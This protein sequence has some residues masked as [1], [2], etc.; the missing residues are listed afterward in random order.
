M[1]K[2]KI[3][4]LAVDAGIAP[5]ARFDYVSP[6][7][8]ER[9]AAAIEAEQAEIIAA[10]QAKIDAL[11]LEYCPNEMTTEQIANWSAHQKAHKPGEQ[12]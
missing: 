9:F 3:I 11:M 10:Q 5:V 4:K 1:D 7:S 8:L 6:L 2:E 12:K